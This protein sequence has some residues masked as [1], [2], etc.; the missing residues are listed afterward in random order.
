MQLRQEPTWWGDHEQWYA[1]YA[2]FGY[3]QQQ[4]F[5]GRERAQRALTAALFVEQEY[6]GPARIMERDG[7]TTRS[8]FNIQHISPDLVNLLVTSELV[9][10]AEK[11]LGS[12]VYIHQFHINYKKAFVG[13]GFFW[14]S[15]YT[16][17]HWEDGM[18]EPRC[19]SM[20]VPLCHL[21]YHNSPLY[22]SS[23]SH[24]F[25]DH[26]VYF[27]GDD[28]EHEEE[29]RHDEFDAGAVTEDMK[30]YLRDQADTHVFIGSPGDLFVMDANLLHMSEP[31]YSP[32]DRP[33]AFICLNSIDNKLGTPFSGNAPRPEY[34][35]SRTYEPLAS[36]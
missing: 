31:N 29:I 14:H 2:S 22:V 18:P 7:V 21:S 10:L 8:I 1:S 19:V 3:Y 30:Q 11:I 17:W 25:Y 27:R 5:V 20:V 32:F 16:Y 23:G 33:C 36:A 34:L 4:S 9:A 13:G 28:V 12:Q 35:S 6:E 15:D 26:D 24:L